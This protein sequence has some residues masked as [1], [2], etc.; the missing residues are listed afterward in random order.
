MV[1]CL[2]RVAAQLMDD[3]A[4]VRLP[5]PAH[6]IVAGA[7]EHLAVRRQGEL[8]DPFVVSGLHGTDRLM[9]GGVPP[10]HLAIRPGR[11][12]VLLRQD[13]AADVAEVAGPGRRLRLVGG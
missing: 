4:R 10:D 2:L 9:S 6:H 1:P 3:L 5:Q 11:D 12:E 7:G 8:A 13:Q